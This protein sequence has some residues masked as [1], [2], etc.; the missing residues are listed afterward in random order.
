MA[1]PQISVIIPLWNGRAYIDTCLDAL[2]AASACCEGPVEILVVDN[3]STDGSAQQVADHFPQVQLIRNGRNLGFAGGCNVGLRAAC[4]ETLVL[5]NQDTEVSPTW[6]P[7]LTAA[8]DETSVM[9][10]L[11]FLADGQT[12]Q[13]AGGRIEWPLG[14]AHHLGYGEPLAERWQKPAQVDFVTAAA[15]AFPRPLLNK[16]GFFDERFWPGYYEDADF[17]YRAR[18]VGYSIRYLPDAILIHQ[19]HTSFRDRLWTDWAR[20]RGRL[21]FCLKHQAPAFFLEHFLPAEEHYR[22]SVV[23][24]DVHATVAV[25][26]LEAIPMLVDLWGTRATQQQIRQASV[27]L[28]A[29]YAPQPFHVPVD[30]SGD[31]LI[32]GG[33]NLKPRQLSKAILTPS[34]LERVPILGPVWRRLRRTLHHLVI[35]YVAQRQGQ[36]EAMIQHQGEEIARLR[37]EL[38]QLTRNSSE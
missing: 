38:A 9:G 36:Q 37:A 3:G 2:L 16:I 31:N 32:S 8:V 10:S 21:R 18:E 17:C 1:D 27:R 30:K 12:I 29:L 23:S 15:M 26:Y 6:L 34:S 4:G 19:E 11:A 13:H 20:L 25:A 33:D 28:E 24:G 35:F 7:L 22:E 14:I 5:L